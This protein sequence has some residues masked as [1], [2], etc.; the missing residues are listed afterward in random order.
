MLIHCYLYPSLLGFLLGFL[1]WFCGCGFFGLVFFDCTDEKGNP[2]PKSFI[3]CRERLSFQ[4][5]RNAH[6]LKGQESTTF[7]SRNRECVFL[8]ICTV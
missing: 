1:E 6:Q 2:N 5:E 8:T 4:G 3:S 7:S